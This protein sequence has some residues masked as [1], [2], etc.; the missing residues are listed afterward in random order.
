MRTPDSADVSRAG[1]TAGRGAR[2]VAQSAPVRV[3]ARV[4]IAANGVLHLLIGWLAVQVALGSGGQ[5]DQNGA[6]GAIAAE[7]LGR[8]LLWVLVV[9]F[10]AVVLWRSVSAVWGFGY[11]GDRKKQLAKRAVSAGLAVVY[12]V[13]ALNVRFR[14]LQH[15]VTNLLMMWFFLTPIIYPATTV[16]ER[17]RQMMIF[18]NPMAILVSSYQAIFYEHRLPDFVPL[19]ALM[20][21]ALVLLW[22][23]AQVFEAR[24]EEFA[25]SI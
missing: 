1:R 22:V 5:A 23:A 18:V 14:D 17:F 9:G 19:L 11:L 16:P 7:P 20:S 12:L 10:G 3:A 4:G 6:L 25:E 24:R 2:T 8:A 13:S 21:G 15:I